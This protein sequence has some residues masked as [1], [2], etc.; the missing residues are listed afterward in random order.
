ME[1]KKFTRRDDTE[2]NDH[3]VL[4]FKTKLRK[5]I[6]VFGCAFRAPD[7]SHSDFFSY[8]ND[9]V[10]SKTRRGKEII[11]AGDLNCN[12]NDTS[13]SQTKRAMEFIDSNSLTQLITECTRHSASSSSRI[14]LL[15]TTTPNLFRRYGALQSSLSDH[16]PIYEVFPKICV[17]HMHRYIT[18]RKWDNTKMA[19]F[20]NDLQRNT[21][22]EKMEEADNL[23]M[24]TDT[25][26]TYFTNALDEHFPLCKKRIRK[27]SHPWLDRSTLQL[28]RRR[29][30][31]TTLHEHQASR[32]YGIYTN[33]PC[34]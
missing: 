32:N 2:E 26:L 10:G 3:E 29:T 15:I 22:W 6:Y 20:V 25:W 16:Q 11:I 19:G 27:N 12:F 14:D 9:I 24:K 21:P 7:H 28:I 1:G 13:T 8:L 23:D 5:T 31:S 4:W 18:S 34:D 30:Q 17:Y 33:N